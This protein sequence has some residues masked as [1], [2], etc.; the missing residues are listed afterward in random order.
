MNS[1]IEIMPTC[2]IVYMR[3]VGPYGL[4]NVQIIQQLKKWAQSNNLFNNHAI[5]LGIAQDNP[6]LTKVE[7]CRYDACLV[8]P[9]DYRIVR[10]D[11]RQ[12]YITGGKYAVFKVNHTD[13]AVAKAWADIFPELS[14]Q[15]YKLDDKRP[16]IERYKA[17][18][19]KKHFC[20]ICVPVD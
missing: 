3:K 6:N 17:R 11:M 19:V 5:I 8:V 15:G 2:K 12:G 7:D 20:E 10:D 4:E 14:K 18:M 9:N 13:E 16:I 1:A